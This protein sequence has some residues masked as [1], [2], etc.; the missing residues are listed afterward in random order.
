MGTAAKA[1]V[2]ALIAGLGA[3]GTALSDNSIAPIEWV[4]VGSATLIALYGVWRVPNS[5]TEKDG[6]E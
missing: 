2:G 5:N 1:V 3:L 4:G 6:E